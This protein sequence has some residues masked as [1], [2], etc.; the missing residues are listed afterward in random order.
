MLMRGHNIYD[1]LDGSILAPPH[2]LSQNNQDT[3]NP[4]F[5]VWFC[6]DHL[7][8]NAILA[9]VEPTLVATAD[10]TKVPWV[11]LHSVY[12]NKS[13]TRI[14]SLCDQLAR[15]TKDT[16]PVADYLHQVRCYGNGGAQRFYNAYR[17][18]EATNL[19]T[20]EV[21]VNRHINRE[22]IP[23][24]YLRKLTNLWK[25]IKNL[26]V[27][28]LG[29]EFCIAKFTSWGTLVCLGKF[30]ICQTMETQFC[31]ESFNHHPHYNLGKTAVATNEINDKG[32]LGKV[33][34]TLGSLMKIDTCTSATRHGN[35]AVRGGC[36]A[37]LVQP[38]KFSTRPAP[39]PIKSLR[40][41][42]L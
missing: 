8:Q 12:P 39:P 31:N 29:W 7:I 4:V 15:V 23:H 33:G 25:P 20:M 6:Q 28:D 26:I 38:T 24:H 27:I 18:R 10:S 40:S 14:F 30:P 13:Q 17:G 36:E 11:D 21:L 5:L 37:Y 3:E 16:R 42:P 22:R 41:A 34:K 19:P 35:G 1:H 2:T 9:S 32:I